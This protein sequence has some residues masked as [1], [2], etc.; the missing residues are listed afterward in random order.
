MYI[1]KTEER[2]KAMYKFTQGLIEDAS[3]CNLGPKTLRTQM[4]KRSCPLCRKKHQAHESS[5][6]A[7]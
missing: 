3:L 6:Q 4:K 1:I 5:S 7:V 2:A